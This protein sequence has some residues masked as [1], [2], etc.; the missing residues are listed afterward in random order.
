MTNHP[1]SCTLCGRRIATGTQSYINPPRKSAYFGWAARVCV[2]P[3]CAD[4]H[5]RKAE[6]A[7][8]ARNED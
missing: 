3:T 4:Q 7:L 1:L 6:A 8:H 5:R 2:C